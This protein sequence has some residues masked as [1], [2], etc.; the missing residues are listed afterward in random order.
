VVWGLVASLLAAVVIKL[1][2]A[3]P[4]ERLVRRYFLQSPTD[5]TT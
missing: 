4:P 2:T 3:P 5:K 1:L